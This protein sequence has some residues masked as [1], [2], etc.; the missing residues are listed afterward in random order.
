[1]N[2]QGQIASIDLLVALGLLTL[3]IGLVIVHVETT[4]TNRLQQKNRLELETTALLA[5]DI[6]VNHPD[7]T[8]INASVTAQKIPN[9]I[10]GTLLNNSTI[11]KNK[12]GLSDAFGYQ[13][14]L[15]QSGSNYVGELMPSNADFIEIR[16]SVLSP[17]G[18]TIALPSPQL[19]TKTIRLRVWRK[20]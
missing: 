10:P 18:D 1:M 4:S 3:A 2:S 6:L 11:P 15:D 19:E 14:N 8:C 12:L 16:R 7:W 20:P 5:S 13:I 9:C 17:N